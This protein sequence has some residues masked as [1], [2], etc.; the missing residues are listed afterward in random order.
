MT[1]DAVKY[2]GVLLLLF[3]LVASFV[4][5]PLG[6]PLF[7]LTFLGTAMLMAALTPK[8]QKQEVDLDQ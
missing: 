3:W 4:V 5:P 6:C 1:R 2:T 7:I 8:Q